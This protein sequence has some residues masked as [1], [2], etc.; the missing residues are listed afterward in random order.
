MQFHL[1][2]LLVNHIYISL[3]THTN[4]SDLARLV[5]VTC[6]V[7]ALGCLEVGFIVKHGR[8]PKLVVASAEFSQSFDLCFDVVLRHVVSSKLGTV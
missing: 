7:S 8:N 4:S 5:C 1:L 3:Y 2:L 6:G